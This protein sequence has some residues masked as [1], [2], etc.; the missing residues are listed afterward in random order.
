MMFSFALIDCWDYFGFCLMT[1]NRKALLIAIHEENI[2]F[3]D[4]EFM[5]IMYVICGLRNENERDLNPS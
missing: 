4:C 2:C 1:T 5:K 3:N